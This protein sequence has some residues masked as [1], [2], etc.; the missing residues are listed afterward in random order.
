MKWNEKVSSPFE[1]SFDEIVDGF[2]VD[3]LLTGVDVV[4]VVEREWLVVA[5]PRLRLSRRLRDARFAR[6]DDFPGQL[7]P[8]SGRHPHTTVVRSALHNKGT[9]FNM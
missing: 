8:D 9:L 1:A 4:N 7:G 6:V 5:Q 2:A 3:V